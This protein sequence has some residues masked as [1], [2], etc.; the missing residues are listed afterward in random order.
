[1]AKILNMKL[2]GFIK[3]HNNLEEAHEFKDILKKE[4]TNLTNLDSIITYLNDGVLLL[5]WMGYFMDLEDND[6]ISPD[7][8]Y[9]DGF[10][11]WPAYFPYYLA[12]YSKY[13]I[14][15]DFIFH[16]SN[17]KYRMDKQKL[18]NDQMIKLENKLSKKL[19]NL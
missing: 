11:I 6:L 18:Q 4:S 7:S 12:K 17:N 9:T 19:N 1:L 13:S 15:E 10:Y 5:G 16:L 2:I 14:D 8:Y 3:E